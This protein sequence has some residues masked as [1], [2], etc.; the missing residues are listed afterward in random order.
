M[1]LTDLFSKAARIAAMG[2]GVTAVAMTT[3]AS[4]DTTQTAVDFGMAGDNCGPS[5]VYAGT[6]DG[7]SGF[8]GMEIGNCGDQV[9]VSVDIG[10]GA[11]FS[12]T[13]VTGWNNTDTGDVND[14]RALTGDHFF[15]NWDGSG[16]VSFSFDGLNPD[17]ILVVDFADRKGGERALVT[18]E[19]VDTMVEGVAGDDGVFTNV[20]VV[21]GSSSYSGSFTGPDGSGEGNLCGA[22]F[23]IISA[24]K[25]SGP[26]EACCF[27]TD[28]WEIGV[29]DCLA[30]GGANGGKGSVCDA[31]ACA[32]PE[33]LA[34]CVEGEG[35]PGC[36]D[37]V[38][39][40]AVCVDLPDC[41]NV[42]WD[43]DCAAAAIDICNDCDGTTNI[44]VA[45]IDFGM[46]GGN[47]GG[48]TPVYSGT[49]DATGGFAGMEIND[50]GQ[51]VDVSFDLGD[52]ASFSFTNVTGW[53]NTDGVPDTSP[54]ALTGDHFFSNWDGSGPVSFSLDGLDPC[55]TVILEF[56]DRRGG[57]RAGVDFNGSFTV[58]D[59]VPDGDGSGV[60]TNVSGEGVTG[61][62]SYGGSFTGPDGD[63]EG[64]LAGAKIVIIPG[65]EDCGG[66]CPGDFDGNGIVD[67]ADFGFMIAAWGPCKCPED[68]NGDGEVDGAD[69]GLFVSLWGVCP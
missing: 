2:V 25:G 62:S 68:L 51:Q 66:T 42:L 52:G 43:A 38:C 9:D 64:N 28:C 29:N 7:T 45:A 54:Q 14:V 17:D 26:I 23:T 34:C 8:V 36:L 44:Q 47:C 60:F 24:G 13:N 39:A 15:S 61:S 6:F 50:C 53:N 55:D 57:E 41:C 46:V 69:V 32:P 48:P 12:F 40:N 33:L 21:T 56:A 58:I 20:G 67:G 59:G 37:I 10:G 18:F 63:G 22:R 49:F 19:G 30:A 65:G 5:P 31:E 4:A 1:F 11:S 27:G 35:L 3:A 16:P